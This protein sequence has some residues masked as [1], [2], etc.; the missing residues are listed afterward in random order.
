MN[1]DV[2][3]LVSALAVG[4]VFAAGLVVAMGYRGHSAYLPVASTGLATL[5]CVIWALQSVRAM[6]AAP[7]KQFGVSAGELGRFAQ[8]VLM[9]AAYVLVTTWA[10]F[11]TATFIM[12]PGMAFVLGYRHPRMA[13]LVTAIFAAV[14]YG[15]FRLLLS[16][17]LPREAVLTFL[18]A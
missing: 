8:I 7:S 13:F 6:M 16:I 18:G 3:E 12:V 1:R 5:L 9:A 11:F 10:G 2:V 14:L 17:P 15:V 4:L